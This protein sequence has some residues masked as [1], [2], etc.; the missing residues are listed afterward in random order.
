MFIEPFLAKSI[1][2]PSPIGKIPSSNPRINNASPTATIIS[3][4]TID[5]RLQEYIHNLFTNNAENAV[6]RRAGAVIVMDIKNGE[7]LASGSFPEY[8]SNIF[9]NGISTKD[10]SKI[11]NDFNHPFTNKI[12]NGLYPPGSVVK[13][14]SHCLF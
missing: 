11:I 4:T 1:A 3:P 14:V 6:D 5:I 9:V 8:D 7:I 13:W 2:S 10:W 12:I